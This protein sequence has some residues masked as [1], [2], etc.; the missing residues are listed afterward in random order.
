[1][2]HVYAIMEDWGNRIDKMILSTTAELLVIPKALLISQDLT[3]HSVMPLM[4]W[5]VHE[6]TSLHGLPAQPSVFCRAGDFSLSC[7]ES[8]PTWVSPGI[9]LRI[10][11][12]PKLKPA[13]HQQLHLTISHGTGGQYESPFGPWRR[14][15]N[16]RGRP[17]Y[18]KGYLVLR[19]HFHSVCR[20]DISSQGCS[21]AKWESKF[22]HPPS[23]WFTGD[24]MAIAVLV[25]HPRSSLH[26]I[27]SSSSCRFHIQDVGQP[28]FR[29]GT[30]YR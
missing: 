16:H 25:P 10:V 5:R 7:N 27:F 14:M 12:L 28:L 1:M 29:S 24:Y 13:S 3:H 4:P 6:R 19:Q 8:R 2:I 15:V 22:N 20:V 21:C 11:F 9:K 17:V 23:R 26:A 30:L 18:H